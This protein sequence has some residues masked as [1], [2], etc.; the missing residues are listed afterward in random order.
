MAVKMERILVP[1]DFSIHSE[2]ALRAALSLKK[3][4]GAEVTV[5]HV[6]DI[7]EMLGL[8]W[9]V[10]GESL[11]AEV[12]A[13][14]EEDSRKAL[15][16]FVMK[17]GAGEGELRTLVARGRPFV[18][19]VRLAR[20]ENVDLVVMGTHGRKGIEHLLLGSNAEKV[21]RKAPCSVLTVR[22]REG[23]RELSFPAGTILVPTDFSLTSERAM[24]MA[25]RLAQ[26][27]SSR[28]VLLH[29]FADLKVREAIQ[30]TEY[31]PTGQTELELEEGIMNRAQEELD[32]FVSKFPVGE[33]KVD[34]KVL[35]EVPHRGIVETAE[36]E[37]VD[38]IV[39]GTHGRSG[40]NHL[41]M[42]SVAEKVVRAS[43]SP[44]LT[45]KPGE[46]SFEM[47]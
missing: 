35:S 6:F 22:H 18:E 11:E 24:S 12:V 9:T 19:V 28:I 40:L 17:M 39:M 29:V 32:A 30:W 34:K 21:V 23:Q 25:I 33:I 26:R 43:P 27:N 5:I 42:G 44:V 37:N 20:S 1:T 36:Q 7:S 41:I 10:Y 14:M 16:Q 45:V 46:H 31:L 8:G 38:L 47:P 4:F 3:E 2:D 13:R 15:A